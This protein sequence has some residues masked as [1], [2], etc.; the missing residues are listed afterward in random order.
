MLVWGWK[1]L[2]IFVWLCMNRIHVRLY[3]NYMHVQRGWTVGRT[4]RHRTIAR[5]TLCKSAYWYNDHSLVELP[6]TLGESFQLEYRAVWGLSQCS[7]LKKNV[8]KNVINVL[9][10]S[11]MF[12]SLQQSKSKRM[13]MRWKDAKAQTGANPPSLSAWWTSSTACFWI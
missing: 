12:F 2:Y 9:L 1:R 8:P 10:E 7:S 11:K 6:R 3:I 5:L 4:S 13:K